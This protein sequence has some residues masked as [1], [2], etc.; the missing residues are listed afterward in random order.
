MINSHIKDAYALIE[1]LA[2]FE[3]QISVKKV[4]TWDEIS[5]AE[6]LLEYRSSQEGFKGVSFNTISGFGPNGAVIHYRAAPETVA[7]IDDS[8]LFLRKLNKSD[9]I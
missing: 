3:D 2:Y 6:K 5:A 4:T 9:Q 8:S 1:F 7:K